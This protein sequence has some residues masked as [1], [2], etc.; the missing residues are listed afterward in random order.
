MRDKRV[1][2]PTPHL[3]PRLPRRVFE[4]HDKGVYGFRRP[5][6][7]FGANEGNG[8]AKLHLRGVGQMSVSGKRLPVRLTRQFVRLLIPERVTCAFEFLRGLA[9]QS[10]P[11]SR[12]E[13][14]DNENS[15]NKGAQAA[16]TA[17]QGRQGRR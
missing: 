10:G 4:L 17:R 12:A 13:R 15:G 9:G 8:N 3:P 11:H 7:L 16:H 6:P 14:D 5:V 1:Q 2:S